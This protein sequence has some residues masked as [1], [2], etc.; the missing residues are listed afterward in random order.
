MRKHFECL[1]GCSVRRLPARS[2]RRVVC[3][4]IVFSNP[5]TVT[6]EEWLWGREVTAGTGAHYL[7]QNWDRGWLTV[8]VEGPHFSRPPGRAVYMST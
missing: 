5:T 2:R 3:A 1:P 8:L 7:V 4:R 6:A